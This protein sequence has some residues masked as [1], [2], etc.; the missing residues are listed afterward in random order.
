MVIYHWWVLGLEM[1]C[2]DPLI[3]HDT[4]SQ[5]RH[6]RITADHEAYEGSNRSMSLLEQS[7]KL[8][9][10]MGNIPHSENVAEAI[11]ETGEDWCTVMAW[12]ACAPVRLYL[13]VVVRGQKA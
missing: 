1:A 8:S 6:G 13:L 4:H 3:E 2:P 5:H 11:F 9:L 10:R 12:D 7:R